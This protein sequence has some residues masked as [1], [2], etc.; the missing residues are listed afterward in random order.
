M[1]KLNKLTRV[2]EDSQSKH[3][4]RL[5]LDKWIAW[6]KDDGLPLAELYSD[7][8]FQR[9]FDLISQSDF[10]VENFFSLPQMVKTRLVTYIETDPELLPDFAA[11][12][13]LLHRMTMLDQ[14]MF[15]FPHDTTRYSWLVASNTDTIGIVR[16]YIQDHDELGNLSIG[17][18]LTHQQTVCSYYSINLIHITDLVIHLLAALYSTSRVREVC[19]RWIALSEHHS[20]LDLVAVADNWENVRDISIDWAVQISNNQSVRGEA[21]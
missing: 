8:D 21:L 10:L 5:T 11:S 2:V 4:G 3:H 13:D 7:D 16:L 19:Q 12:V 17:D 14:S 15:T 20:L 9:E 1:N 6:A 18:L